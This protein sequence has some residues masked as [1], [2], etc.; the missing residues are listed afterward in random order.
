MRFGKALGRLQDSLGEL[1]DLA[2]ASNG[3]YELFSDLD[4]ITAAKY[5]AQLNKLL[6]SLKK[7]RQKLLKIAEKSI[8]EIDETP[9]WWK[10][11]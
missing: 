8:A 1:N 9:A 6:A 7:S 10:A 5:T 11:D 3:Q 4:A 2:I